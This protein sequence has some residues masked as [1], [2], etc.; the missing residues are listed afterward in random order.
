MDRVLDAVAK[1]TRVS[2][3]KSLERALGLTELDPNAEVKLNM[4]RDDQEWYFQMGLIKTKVEVQKM[5][6]LRFLQSA[7]QALGPYR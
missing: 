7:L 1:Y 3:R 4:I 6:D 2:D 5:A